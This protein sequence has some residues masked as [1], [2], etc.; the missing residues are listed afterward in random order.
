MKKALIFGVGRN[1][2]AYKKS[3][4]SSYEIIGLADNSHSKQGTIVDNYTIS[5]INDFSDDEMDVI[6]VTPTD[7][8]EMIEQLVNMGFETEKIIDVQNYYDSSLTSKIRISFMFYGGMGDFL[9]GKNWLYYLDKIYNFRDAHIDIFVDE[10]AL[11]DAKNVFGDFEKL[12]CLYGTELRYNAFHEDSG[13]DLS[14]KFCIFPYVEYFFGDKLVKSNKALL[15]Y[16]LKLQKF[17]F[18]NYP[19]GFCHSPYYY[20]TIR[21]LFEIFN[22]KYHNFF[23]V[24]GD[25][26]VGDKFLYELPIPEKAASYLEKCDLEPGKYIT[27]NTGLNLGYINLGNT[28]A[29][30]HHSWNELAQLLRNNF[31]EIKVVQIGLNMT[32]NDDIEADLNL[33]GKTDFEEMK[34][35]L[36]N[37]L[38]HVD[39]D[40]GLVHVRHILHGGCSVVLFGPSY[41]EWHSYSENI[42]IQTDA[43]DCCEWTDGRWLVECP[44]GQSYPKC[45]KSIRPYDVFLKIR[46]YI[47]CR[48]M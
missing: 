14:F 26:E 33:N 39:Y 4:F 9:I 38:V 28:R 17:G 3:I 24:F 25:F 10:K 41:K 43:C 46:E 48:N 27:L 37:A 13:Y 20:K 32:K 44:K 8:K 36:Q 31:P 35:L 29:W 22:R 30:A 34:V 15:D 40:G 5:D 12:A 1:Y 19:Y 16:V 6:L 47:E 11:Y 23:D 42:S 2:E 45:M 7:G 18:D 21:K